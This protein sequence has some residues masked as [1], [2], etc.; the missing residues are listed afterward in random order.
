MYLHFFQCR[1]GCIF[2]SKISLTNGVIFIIK[3]FTSP[4]QMS[5]LKEEILQYLYP[6]FDNE[7]DSEEA[8]EEL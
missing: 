8:V 7:I 1:V 4:P 5:N 2:S 3:V 6:L